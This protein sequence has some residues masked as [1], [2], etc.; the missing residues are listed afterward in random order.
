MLNVCSD[1]NGGSILVEGY[2]SRINSSSWVK[3]DGSSTSTLGITPIPGTDNIYYNI[4]EDDIINGS[5]TL[6]LSA[7]GSGD[8]N[9]N[10]ESTT[11]I[12]IYQAINATAGETASICDGNNY[13]IKDSE[14]FS[15]PNVIDRIEWTVD[16]QN[17]G[18][19]LSS[20]SIHPT[21]VPDTNFTGNEVQLTL[22]IYPINI[23]VDSY[24]IPEEPQKSSHAPCQQFSMTKKLIIAN[25]LTNIST[26]EIESDS[27]DT[28]CSDETSVKFSISNLENALLQLDNS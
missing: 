1:H 17:A 9:V 12:Q 28:I 20:D 11:L 15:D 23:P 25:D 6:K 27:G 2:A 24:T 10:S 13:E 18:T 7:T 5:V 4:Q 14:I 19:L 8:C 22:K 26:A 21:F 3:V 16:T